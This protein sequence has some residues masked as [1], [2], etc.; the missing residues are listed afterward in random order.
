[1]AKYRVY[2][3]TTASTAVEVEAESGEAAVETALERSL[4]HAGAFC[5]YDLG[6]WTTASD[7][8]PRHNKPEDDYDLIEEQGS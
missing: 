8:D 2:L 4:P 1:M 7:M 6:D 5:G 3:V